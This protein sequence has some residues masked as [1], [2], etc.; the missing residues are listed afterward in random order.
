[1]E[2]G[3]VN[4]SISIRTQISSPRTAEVASRIITR[5]DTDDDNRLSVSELSKASARFINKIDTNSDS[6]VDQEELLTA[7]QRRIGERTDIRVEVSLNI[8]VLK[9]NLGN[10]LSSIL[11]SDSGSNPL[12]NTF[13][14][15]ILAD[16]TSE[17]N[18]N[19]RERFIRAFILNGLENRGLPGSSNTLSGIFDSNATISAL[20]N[21]GNDN[22]QLLLS[23]LIDQLNTPE[24]EANEILKILQEQTFS[25]VA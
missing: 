9:A 1:M 3:A 8:N 6:F 23:L 25:V 14:E 12:S 22:R 2:I 5:N 19:T 4:S 10:L 7:L 16:G 18:T 24:D 17:V 11:S 15:S 13:N 20:S 21:G